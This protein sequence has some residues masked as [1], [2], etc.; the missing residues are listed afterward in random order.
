MDRNLLLVGLGGFIGSVLR[1][2]ASL[3]FVQHTSSSFPFATLTVN[4]LGCFLIGLIV[5]LGE[6]WTFLTPEWRI[7]LTTGLCGGFTTFSTFS[8][9]SFGLLQDGQFLFLSVNIALSLIL[10]LGATYLAILLV[11]GL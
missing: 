4:V 5:A 11:R 1:Y 2:L 9:E 3:A 6:R 8:Y 10:G 7:F